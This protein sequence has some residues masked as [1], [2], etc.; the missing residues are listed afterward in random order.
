MT[1]E[2]TRE[3]VRRYFEQLREDKDP[4]R[5]REYVA[6]QPLLEHIAFYE[7]VL[8]GY[9]LEL[10][11]TVVEGDKVACRMVLHGTHKGELMGIPPS[12]KTVAVDG[13]I[14]Y[15]LANGKIVD[16]WMQTDSVGM[17]QQ[18]GALPTPA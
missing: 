2:E 16:H 14:I 5:L 9:W 18:I 8:P 17:L 7:S 1:P 10:L 4:S 6:E 11:D 13:I 15:Q 12:G 3:F